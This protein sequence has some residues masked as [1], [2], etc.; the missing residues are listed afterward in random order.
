MAYSEAEEFMIRCL[1]ERLPRHYYFHNLEHTREVVAGVEAIAAAEKISGEDLLLL[2]TAALFHDAGYMFRYADNEQPGADFA[3]RELPR[4]GYSVPMIDRIRELILSTAFPQHPQNRQQQ[5]V[6]DA[7]LLY[8]TQPQAVPRIAAFRRE[9]A[10]IG[11]PY[12]DAQWW[13]LEWK[14]LH[15]QH[16][17]LPFNETAY[18]RVLPELLK[19]LRATLEVGINEK[20]FC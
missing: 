19:Q 13:Q 1:S 10:A 9:L 16:F 15:G 2:R 5:I 12:D 8:L 17:F 20:D 14:F 11:T 18:Q 3:A 7:D 4:F 6:C